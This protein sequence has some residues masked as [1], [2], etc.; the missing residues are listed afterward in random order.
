MQKAVALAAAAFLLGGCIYTPRAVQGLPSGGPWFALPLRGWLSEGRALPE[1]ITACGSADCESRLAAGVFRLT[2]QQAT[3]ALAV[4]RNPAALER[5]LREEDA[6]AAAEKGR[7]PAEIRVEALREGAFP[8]FMLTITSPDGSR[9]PLY[10]AAIG[11]SEGA[12]L[13]TIIVIGQDR[14]AVREAARKAA[15]ES[16]A[17]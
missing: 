3:E 15:Q 14:Q 13:R 9:P 10:G 2:G 1:A 16:L 12:A 6:K 11:A 7:R 4:L 17:G 5:V 8:G